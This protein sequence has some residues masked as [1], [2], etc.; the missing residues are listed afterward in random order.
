MK[1]LLLFIYLIAMTI[2]GIHSIEQNALA[3][4]FFMVGI[5]AGVI[6]FGLSDAEN[7]RDEFNKGWED[8]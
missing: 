4:A 5:A 3:I 1:A 6:F 2:L 8:Q 7:T